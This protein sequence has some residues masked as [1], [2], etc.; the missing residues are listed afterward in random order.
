VELINKSFDSFENFQD[1]FEKK[2]LSLFGSGWVWLVENPDL[3]ILEIQQS[4]NQESPAMEFMIERNGKV[5][6]LLNLD[7]WEHAYY[8]DYQNRRGDFVKN[9]W[10]IIN[11]KKV[12]ERLL[13]NGES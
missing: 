6:P 9:F 12:E 1:E 13:E 3:G 4:F 2:A 10:Q 11:W 8:P 7:V 5:N